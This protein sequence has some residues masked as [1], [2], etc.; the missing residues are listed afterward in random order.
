M[1]HS[2]TMSKTLTQGFV[3]FLCLAGFILSSSY[4]Y[5]LFHV[6]A[7]GFSIVVAFSIFML[8]WNTR[9]FIENGYLQFLG[10]AYLFIGGL[11]GIHTLAY[12]GM[13]IFPDYDADLPT[14]LWIA[15]R[16]IQSLSFLIAPLFLRKKFRFT[17]FFWSYAA[18]MTLLTVAIFTG[19]FPDCFVEGVGLTQFKI[20][21]EYLISGLLLAALM[22][23]YRYREQ[24]DAH[25]LELLCASLLL[26]I[27]S[28][29][30]FTFYL[31]VYGLSNLIG[32]LLKIVSFYLIYKAIISTGLTKPYQLLLRNLKQSEDRLQDILNSTQQS[33]ALIDRSY[34]ILAYNHVADEKA[35]HIFGFP[36]R[37][38]NSIL[39]RVLESDRAAFTQHFARALEGQT[40][41]V[42]R[43]VHDQEGMLHWFTFTYNPAIA[44]DGQVNAVCLNIMESTAQKQAEEQLRKMWR[45]L[46]YLLN[47]SPA[48]IYTCQSEGNFAATFISENIQ[49]LVG[50]D[51]Y[52]FLDDPNFWMNHIHP[53]DRSRALHNL[54]HIAETGQCSHEYR[55]LH[56]NGTYRWILDELILIRNDQGQA[57][58]IVGS[59][60]DITKQR[61][62]GRRT[63][64]GQRLCRG[65]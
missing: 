19:M 4:N 55:F 30:A 3:V 53:D 37:T 32:H 24:F 10:I 20:V 14:Q 17:L 27:V 11:D 15:A 47:V 41:I 12:K 58:E 62:S 51:A 22:I 34:T 18:V 35:Q 25:V 38:G 7:E 59:L 46:E 9:Q 63:A 29:L 28:E 21:S 26:T 39:H 1:A 42:Q 40:V 65:G 49:K 45:R 64:A 6:L 23:L 61:A 43:P 13:L 44:K 5:L 60:T 52:Q 16:Y 48:G 31:S 8:V 56:K 36:L 54:A 2:P 57:I 33:F 50:Y